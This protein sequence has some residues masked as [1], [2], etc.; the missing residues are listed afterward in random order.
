MT[1]SGIV[2][3]GIG[4]CAVA[5]SPVKIKTFGLGSC[6]GIVLYDKRER[7]G[8]LVHTMLPT[9]EPIASEKPVKNEETACPYN[10][11]L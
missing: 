5:R 2:V 10:F 8:G 9:I 7:I 1:D 6:V 11:R 3:V 4:A